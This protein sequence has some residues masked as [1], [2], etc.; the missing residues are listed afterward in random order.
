MFWQEN[1]EGH[2]CLQVIIFLYQPAIL[3]D[4][5]KTQ[6]L[7]SMKLKRMIQLCPLQICLETLSIY[8]HLNMGMEESVAWFEHVLIQ[9]KCCLFPV[10]L[11]SFHR[12]DRRHYI[13]AVKV[14]DRKPSMFYT[15][16]V[17]SLIQCWDNSEQNARMRLNF[18]H[19]HYR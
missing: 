3:K 10:L 11:S 16:I 1:I 15:M 2:L 7:G 14:F 5:W 19:T 18:E 8:I 12:R 17:K 6:F 4:A 9:I 13:R